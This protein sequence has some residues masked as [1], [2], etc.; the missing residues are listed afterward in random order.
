MR[1][2]IIP[3]QHLLEK[4]IHYEEQQ[5]F[6]ESIYRDVYKGAYEAIEQIRTDNRNREGKGC[7][8]LKGKNVEIANVISFVGRRGTGKSSSMLSFHES[9]S[10]YSVNREAFYA[11]LQDDGGKQK[12]EKY[13]KNPQNV[14]LFA[15]ECIDASALEENESVFTIVLANIL[16][17]IEECSQKKKYDTEEYQKRSLIKKLEGLYN[18]YSS[19][20]DPQRSGQGEYSSYENLKNLAS[21]QRIRGQFEELVTECLQYFN[22]LGE[23]SVPESYLVIA[24]DD[25]D[26]A[27]YNERRAKQGQLNIRS[28]EI[29]RL[30]SKYF[31]VPGVIVLVAY[32]HKNLYRQCS[33]YFTDSNFRNYDE[34]SDAEENL[35]SGDDLTA[36]FM[37]K[38]F[39]PVYRLYMPSW[40]KL[41][42]NARNIQIS[43]GDDI[44]KEDLFSRFRER[45]DYILS[46]KQL[47]LFLYAERIG[48]Y[49]DCEGRKRH[50]LEPNSL[51][52][53]SNM[54]CMLLEKESLTAE[55]AYQEEVF[56]RIMDDVYFRFVDEHLHLQKE[57]AFFRD[58]LNS[59]IK[60]RGETIVQRMSSRIMPLG[61]TY[62]ELSKLYRRETW[63]HLEYTPQKRYGL[64]WLD[65]SIKKLQENNEEDYSY[66]ELVHCIYHMTRVEE[67]YSKELV[68]CILHSY[69]I[70]LTQIYNSYRKEKK[71]I[72]EKE[73]NKSL[74]I[75]SCKELLRERQEYKDNVD[76]RGENEEAADKEGN[77]DETAYVKGVVI[78]I[79]KAAQ[80]LREVVG[81]TV[82]GKWA[83]YYFPKVYTDNLRSDNAVIIGCFE[84]IRE[85]GFKAVFA[86][87][88][89]WQEADIRQAIK[90]CIFSMLM[91]PD[92][93]Q[94][95]ELKLDIVHKSGGG[96]V[97]GF[98]LQHYGDVRFEL[99][100]FVRASIFYP[101]YLYKME[102]LLCAAFS[103]KGDSEWSQEPLREESDD[104]EKENE[105]E[106][107][108]ER[109]AV[110]EFKRTAQ[111]VIKSEFEELWSEYYEWDQNYGNMILPIQNFDT[112]YNLIKHLFREGKEEN[113]FALNLTKEGAFFS[114]FE[115]MIKRIE[116]HLGSMDSFYCLTNSEKSFVKKFLECP[117]FKLLKD[118]KN[119]QLSRKYVENH[120]KGVAAGVYNHQL[121]Y[122]GGDDAHDDEEVA[123]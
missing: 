61:R 101:D 88:D 86:F 6:S 40:Q 110:K 36:E 50:F 93:P 103:V 83:E 58:L 57:R 62:K 41:D 4:G 52:Q 100:T 72:F 78:K 49:Y 8:K 22:E 44:A 31:S 63:E 74:Y 65:S 33:S 5:E 29:M 92:L 13:S 12:Q 43:I 37:E 45:Q 97:G 120:I 104:G 20:T 108:E 94:W 9:L 73:E 87:G 2:K 89:V 115:R 112:M 84:E 10:K 27:H 76:I 118:V 69:S 1:P 122:L 64:A 102:Q 96:Q 55:E 25:L 75:E 42:Y 119:E 30:I 109:E 68:A 26:M 107:N 7:K 21:S 111:T 60:R 19:L 90:G 116:R 28:Y 113:E 123:P 51:R 47:L 79:D 66:A 67:P 32:N 54:V 71:Q 85:A 18:D 106:W 114:E 35:K 91:Y 24:I 82:F 59:Q 3:L 98:F 80:P 117:Y 15:L 95:T 99:T 81:N 17:K 23:A 53:L 121:L 16:S 38:V 105:E 46:V 56:K 48:I 14:G 70:V 39:A 34:E 11:K 77:Q